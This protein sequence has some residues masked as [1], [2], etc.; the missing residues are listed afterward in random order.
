VNVLFISPGFPTEMPWFVR[1]LA[2]VGARVYGLGESPEAALPDS[3]R[4]VLWGYLQVRSLW[5]EEA[6][7]AEVQQ[8]ALHV[9]IDRVECLWEPGVV[10]AARLREALDLPGMRVEQALRFRDKELMKQALDAAGIRTP[11]HARADSEASGH[12]AAER[13]GFPL[14]VKP[15]AGAGSADT[16]RVDD[17]EQLR[18]VLGLVRHVKE[19]SVEEF[20]EGEEY[21]FDTI[22]SG[23][24]ILYH[25]VSWYRPCPLVA[26]SLEWVS[27]Q[28]VALRNPDRPEL[29]AGTSMGRGV[30]RALD[31]AEG[32]TH[33]EWFLKP[34]GEA[35]FGEI[36]ARPPGALSVDLMNFACD[37]DT[38]VGWAGAV[39]HGRLGQ[40]V[41]RSYNAAV[42]FKRAV[43]QGRIREIRG[44]ERLVARYR[45]HIVSVDLLAVGSPRRNWKQT[46]LSDGNVILRHPELQATLEMADRFGTDLQMVAG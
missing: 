34:D 12:E 26:R 21:T 22:C 8:L 9:A 43:G 14:I 41:R 3:V 2:E 4:Q 46:L 39:C 27:P 20:I 23:G 35:V 10:L 45:P 44:L 36:A 31:F 6:T 24:A 15:I 11:R 13:I 19:V 33:M 7:V 37:I 16:Y 25:N 30:L 40:E 42:V 17:P 29:S 18:R 5:D 28:T 1:G 32:F 38:Y